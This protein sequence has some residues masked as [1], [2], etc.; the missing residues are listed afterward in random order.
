MKQ[1]APLPRVDHVHR[2]ALPS[3]KRAAFW[4]MDRT[5]PTQAQKG[6]KGPRGAA[7]ELSITEFAC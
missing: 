6:R 2:I 3:L 4:G 1:S 7:S 5:W